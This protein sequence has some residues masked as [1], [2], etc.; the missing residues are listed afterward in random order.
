MS[1]AGGWALAEAGVGWNDVHGFRLSF[2]D[3]ALDLRFP[4]SSDGKEFTCNEGDPSSIP[5]S[6]KSLGEGNVYLL[7]YSGLKNPMDRG[8]W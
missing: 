8:S 6:G 7:Q 1:D 3:N 5:G 4:G 2:G